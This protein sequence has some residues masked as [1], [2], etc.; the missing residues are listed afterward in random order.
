[1][2][3]GLPF[4]KCGIIPSPFHNNVILECSENCVYPFL[5][6]VVFALGN[7]AVFVAIDSKAI[8]GLSG[9]SVHTGP[10]NSLAIISVL[11]IDLLPSKDLGLFVGIDINVCHNAKCSLN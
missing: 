10:L 3:L 5:K 8:F 2:G 1:M 6:F 9:P 11:G 4:L 7:S